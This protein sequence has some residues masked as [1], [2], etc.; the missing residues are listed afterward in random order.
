MVLRPQRGCTSRGETLSVLELETESGL[1]L[2]RQQEFIQTGSSPDWRLLPQLKEQGLGV[3]GW[4]AGER[5][6][7]GAASPAGFPVALWSQSEAEEPPEDIRSF[8]PEA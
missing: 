1:K 3:R 7:L 8:H 2:L 6:D 4:G 5:T